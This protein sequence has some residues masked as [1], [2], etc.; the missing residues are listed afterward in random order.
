VR[1]TVAFV[2]LEGKDSS[3]DG[4]GW[5]RRLRD[6]KPGKAAAATDELRNREAMKRAKDD[7]EK[8]SHAAAEERSTRLGCA[9]DWLPEYLEWLGVDFDISQE[10]DILALLK[11]KDIKRTWT[12]EHDKSMHHL[13]QGA[14]FSVIE[15]CATQL[16]AYEAK[17]LAEAEEHI[18]VTERAP[19]FTATFRSLR[20]VVSPDPSKTPKAK[21]QMKK[22]TKA[23]KAR[24][25]VQVNTSE[26]SRSHTRIP[27][28]SS[29]DTEFTTSSS[30][31]AYS[32]EVKAGFLG[33]ITEALGSLFNMEKWKDKRMRLEYLYCLQDF[34][35]TNYLVIAIKN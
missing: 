5:P 2:E 32:E 28:Q 35:L 29:D 3:K 23:R 1:K 34:S 6:R 20:H 25:F 24:R 13:L 11:A 8:A 19:E 27:S 16:S 21:R 17:E 18:K 30:D 14:D 12:H 10:H 15:H 4:W 26:V 22:P 9:S 33:D 31:E 7:Q